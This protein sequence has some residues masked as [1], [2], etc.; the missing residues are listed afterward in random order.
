MGLYR[1]AGG[2]AQRGPSGTI[3]DH[4]DFQDQGSHWS[5][6]GSPEIRS[7]GANFHAHVS[8]V[9]YYYSPYPNLLPFV[10][11][12]W[13]T[14]S[15][16]GRARGESGLEQPRLY[17]ELVNPD[18]GERRFRAIDRAGAAP[19]EWAPIY[20]SFTRLPN[21]QSV[22]FLIGSRADATWVDFDDLFM[23]TE[24]VDNGAFELDDGEFV[25]PRRWQLDG[26]AALTTSGALEG[27]TSVSLPPGAGI[28]RLVAHSSFAVEY[29]LVARADSVVTMKTTVLDSGG[30]ELATQEDITI[31]GGGFV[32]TAPHPSVEGGEMARVTIAN[33]G[34]TPALVDDVSRG[35]VCAWPKVF[36]PGADSEN[37]T[38]HLA[39]AWPGELDTAQL[40]IRTT[41]GTLVDTVALQRDDT[42]VWAD[43][44]G[45]NIP[46][47]TYRARFDLTGANGAACTVEST[48]ELKRGAPLPAR[49]ANFEQTDFQRVAWI[50]LYH[51]VTSPDGAT[52]EETRAKLEL[53][54][55]DGFNLLWFSVRPAQYAL[56]KQAAD[57]V[58]LPYFIAPS[59]LGG[60][61]DTPMGNATF[62]PHGIIDAF[63]SIQIF[64]GD[65]LC[66]GIYLRDE[67]NVSG[68]HTVRRLADV[69]RLMERDGIFP[70]MVTFLSSGAPLNGSDFPFLCTYYYPFSA[71]AKLPETALQQTIA[72]VESN[73]ADAISQGR[74]YWLGTQGYALQ[75]FV[76]VMRESECRAQLAIGLALGMKGYFTFMYNSLDSIAGLRTPTYEATERLAAY[77]DFNLRTQA[78]NDLLMALPASRTAPP[79]SNLLARVAQANSGNYYAFVVN[80]NPDAELSFTVTTNASTTMT[81]VE[82][83]AE[84]TAGTIH[85][86]SLTA[87]EWAIFTFSGGA[88]PTSFTGTLAPHEFESTVSPQVV[89]TITTLPPMVTTLGL[90]PD[91]RK[92]AATRSDAQDLLSIDD[93]D[94]GTSLVMHGFT[95][96]DGAS[97]FLDA[98][99]YVFGSRAFGPRIN[100]DGPTEQSLHARLRHTGGGVD[101]VVDGSRLWLAQSYWGVEVLT[102]TDGTNATSLSHVFAPNDDFRSIRGPFGDGSVI[103]VESAGGVYRLFHDGSQIDGGTTD[104]VAQY[105][106][107]SLANGRLAVGNLDRKF[108]VY[109]LDPNGHV[110]AKYRIDDPDLV[111]AE[112][113]A[114]LDSE[115][116]AVADA[117]LGVRFYRVKQ[118][119]DWTPLGLWM[120]TQ[121]PFHIKAIDAVPNGRIAVSLLPPAVVLADVTDVLNLVEAGAWM[122]K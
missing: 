110:T 16:G 108:T 59:D 44:D 91:G 49:L 52:L 1:N 32:S 112:G 6:V 80:T 28:S 18:S 30:G 73:V 107:P 45:G 62:D 68:P 61:V 86:T 83:S 26:G 23:V 117:R 92:L 70:P 20:G 35:W 94:F 10:V 39:A 85:A 67:P 111:Q 121:R 50:W 38:I 65:P 47:G 122:L 55:D 13:Q 109:N 116:L 2:S 42:T 90:K 3:F 15:V 9:N 54:R 31:P 106:V 74:N 75:D 79:Q 24:K 34:T 96:Q 118:N 12:A 11:P 95:T 88:Q 100:I 8:R 53:A 19:N 84:T 51:P 43:Y 99:R 114:W 69:G 25:F 22:L 105:Y 81:N 27:T 36:E 4:G 56:V 97:R 33:T 71:E 17:F 93:N 14:I 115:V 72:G 63:S 48:F 7:E 57:E 5:A 29:F 60:L 119:G 120:P 103:A 76:P 89:G 58:S 77:S 104:P 113:T 41:G 64:A 102:M 82:T 40:T 66:R 46:A 37:P 98:Q 101:A 87:G 78:L 21:E